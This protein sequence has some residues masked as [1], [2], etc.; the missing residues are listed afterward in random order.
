VSVLRWP[1]GRRGEALPTDPAAVPLEALAV[2]ALRVDSAS[3]RVCAANA[4]ALALL[5]RTRDEVV[6]AHAA[7]LLATPEDAAF[8]AE[9]AGDAQAALQ[10]HATLL[11]ADG[12]TRHVER[13]AQPAGDGRN[14]V[15][16]LI[17]A[18]GQQAAEQARER[19]LAEL[20][21]TLESTADALLVTDL[22]GRMRAWNRRFVELWALPEALLRARDAEAV[23][24][25]MAREVVDPPDDAGRVAR[26]LA[27]ADE[28]AQDRLTLRNGRIV[29]RLS[30][31]QRH[32]ELA[33]G[34]VTS[35]RDLTERV[36][37]DRRAERMALSD[38]LTGLPNRRYLSARLATLL[39]RAGQEGS[40]LAL[41][42]LDLDHFKQIN[43][44]FGEAVGDRVLREVATRLCGALR[45]GDAIA[46]VGGDQFALLLPGCD[47]EGADHAGR[48]LLERVCAPFEVDGQ[49]YTVTCSVGAALYPRDALQPDDLLRHAET[50]M[51]RAKQAG[52]ATWRLH[53]SAVASAELR[54]RLALDHAMRQALAAERFRLHYQPQVALADGRIVGVEALIRWRDPERG[55]IP[56]A[57]FIPVAEDSGFIVA[58]GD[59]VL[60]RAVRQAAQW[61]DQGL[62]LPVAVNVS[63]LQ[64]QHEGFVERVAAVLHAHALPPQLLE[65]ELTE[66]ILLREAREARERMLALAALGVP[67]SIDDFGTGYSSLA[68]LK[69]LPLRRLKIDRAFVRGLPADDGD[70]GIVRAIVQLA[71]ALGL[72]VLA[73]GV[74]TAAQ[75]EFLVAAG[76]DHMQ[77]WL[78]APALDVAQLAHLLRERG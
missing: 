50:A 52:R 49:A 6:G 15:L 27:S 68:Y 35:F 34:R 59:W 37:A 33:C 62:D 72:G 19:L 65:L 74:E 76:C 57:Q 60:E 14:H 70:A 54:S 21:A 66:S 39:A 1:D 75:R 56:P 3:G 12:Q 17:D 9:A 23:F 4:A 7:A 48:R 51:Q 55:D 20:R 41:L 69:Q 38:A 44:S 32:G 8:W 18:T 40:P 53:R 67:L 2:A 25:W 45:E 22:G 26:L 24:A 47:A 10:S 13:S 61:R 63:A 16:T 5:G 43:D 30:L 29:E 58:I 71:H 73:E 77:G 28:P 64:F 31:P 36:E 42:Q 11:R 78:V 46:R